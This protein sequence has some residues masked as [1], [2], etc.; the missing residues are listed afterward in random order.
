MN[1]VAAS[2][3]AACHSNEIKPSHVLK[4]MR[5]PDEIALGTVRFSTGHTLFEIEQF[6]LSLDSCENV[7]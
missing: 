6:V 3:G 7:E 2:P 1:Q 4:A 5:I